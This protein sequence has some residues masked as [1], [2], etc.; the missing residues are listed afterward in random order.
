MLTIKQNVCKNG[1]IFCK[2]A[3]TESE[4]FRF[5]IQGCRVFKKIKMC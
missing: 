5:T 2:M 4:F 3:A 1:G